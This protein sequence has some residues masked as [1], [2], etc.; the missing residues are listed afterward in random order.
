MPSKMIKD[1]H[2]IDN[3]WLIVDTVEDDQLP[4]GKLLLSLALW[5]AHKDSVAER[6]IGLYLK[7]DQNV[8]D[9][10]DELAQFPIIAID[11]P[12]F[13]DGRGFSIARLLRDRYNY[14]GEVR[15][16]G[17]II[18]DQLCYLRRC[19]FN[20]F[21]MSEDIDLEAALVSL[22]DFTESYQTGADQR[23]PLFRRRA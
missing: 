23:T 4:E 21:D 8:S 1:G 18:R 11:F 14:H 5:E 6:D 3:E 19:G 7:N 10:A 2:I 17:A 22:D 16:K 13:A 9:I 20:A 15:A 12:A